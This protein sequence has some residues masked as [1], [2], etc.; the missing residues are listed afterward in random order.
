MPGPLINHEYQ[1]ECPATH[2]KYL[3]YK[4]RLFDN[5]LFLLTPMWTRRENYIKTT[6]A[7]V[8][9]GRS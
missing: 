2:E 1:K 6:T 4:I 5:I 7:E 8:L 9:A 3:N